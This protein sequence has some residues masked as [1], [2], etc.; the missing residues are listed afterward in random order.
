M[1]GCFLGEVAD[2]GLGLHDV[3]LQRRARGV[4]AQHVLR[5]VRGVVLFAAVVVGAGLEDDLLDAAVGAAARRQEV[6][7]ADDVVLVRAAL[8]GHH[9]V[10]HQPGV[11]DRVDLGGLHDPADQRVAVGDLDPL[12]ALEL[13]LRR[14]AIDADDRLDIGILLEALGQAA[15]P[16][17]RQAGD[18]DALRAHPNH[19]LRRLPTM[20]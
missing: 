8:G 6:H 19:T 15:A 16:V 4:R 2:R 3:A 5:E 20:S 11:D 14:T 9:G 10:D 18:E 1:S 12:G 13:D 17:G 7:R